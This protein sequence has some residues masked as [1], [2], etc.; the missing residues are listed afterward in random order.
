MLIGEEFVWQEGSHHAMNSMNA[1]Y[2]ESLTAC[3]NM[4]LK[5][6]ILGAVSRNTRSSPS[7][8]RLSDDNNN[9]FACYLVEQLHQTGIFSDDSNIVVKDNVLQKS[10]FQLQTI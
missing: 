4:F 2:N 5:E 7:G 3:L 1:F 6:L 8:E 10:G 9:Y